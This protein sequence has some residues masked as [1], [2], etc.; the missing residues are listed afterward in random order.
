MLLLFAILRVIGD[1]PDTTPEGRAAVEL[2][3]Q[4]HGTPMHAAT[5]D[6]VA[7]AIALWGMS[8]LDRIEML[9]PFGAEARHVRAYLEY[10]RSQI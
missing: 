6:D 2:A 3:R 9:A 10:V 5:P 1:R 7:F 8:A 4:R